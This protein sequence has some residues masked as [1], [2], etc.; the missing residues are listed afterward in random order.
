VACVAMLSATV[1]DLVMSVVH[2]PLPWFVVC[3]GLHAST[4]AYYVWYYV[5]PDLLWE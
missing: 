5:L 4:L 2:P 3:V 1:L